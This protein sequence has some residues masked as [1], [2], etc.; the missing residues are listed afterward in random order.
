MPLLYENNAPHSSQPASNTLGVIQGL[1]REKFVDYTKDR[2]F[3]DLC[4]P[5]RGSQPETP[6]LDK[7]R[8]GLN[9]AKQAVLQYEIQLVH[10]RY[11]V[12]DVA[13]A[14]WKKIRSD[15]KL[16]SV[17]W[18]PPRAEKDPEADDSFYGLVYVPEE[19]PE[20]G[21]RYWAAGIWD[22]VL[23]HP[24]TGAK[25]YC[26]IRSAGAPKDEAYFTMHPRMTYFGIHDVV[27]LLTQ[28]TSQRNPQPN[29]L[30]PQQGS[31]SR[32][33]QYNS[34]YASRPDQ[35]R[36]LDQRRNDRR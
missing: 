22:G 11:Q 30:Q 14:C 26:A 17:A 21:M 20:T 33:V 31:S 36:S 7:V 34:I 9:S 16:A 5:P 27:E 8:N 13:T 18:K 25:I 10:E 12:I 1:G 4:R 28:P 19:Q 2:V 6:S 32:G 23:A 35:N 24:G 29:V 15:P 3:L